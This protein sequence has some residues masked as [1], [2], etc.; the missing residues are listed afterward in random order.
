[1]GGHWARIH[2]AQAVMGDGIRADPKSFF[3]GGG[4]VGEMEDGLGSKPA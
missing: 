2:P 1:M 4:G 3:F